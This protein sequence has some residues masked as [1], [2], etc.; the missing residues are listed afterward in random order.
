[1]PTLKKRWL[2]IFILFWYN[3]ELSCLIYAIAKCLSFS[4]M[5]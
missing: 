2:L 3:C 4:N 5:D 1:V